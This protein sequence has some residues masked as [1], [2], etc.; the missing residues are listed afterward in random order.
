[1]FLWKVIFPQTM[2]MIPRI[3]MLLLL[4]GQKTL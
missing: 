1:M 2:A 3:L 4:I